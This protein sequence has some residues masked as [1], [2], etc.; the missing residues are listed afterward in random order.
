MTL[1]RPA[2]WLL[3]LATVV[4]ACDFDL[5]IDT[6]YD[7]GSDED[8]AATDEPAPA[9]SNSTSS[10]SSAST[11]PA[12]QSTS[13]ATTARPQ[14]NS[15]ASASRQAKERRHRK[16][17]KHIIARV[18][19]EKDSVS[20][21]YENVNP[22]VHRYAPSYPKTAEEISS[23]KDIVGNGRNLE[24]VDNNYED[25]DEDDDEH[26][27]RLLK[28][29]N[30]L[31]VLEMNKDDDLALTETGRSSSSSQDILLK[32]L[33]ANMEKEAKMQKNNRKH[34]LKQKQKLLEL[35]KS[36]WELLLKL[37]EKSIKHHK[38]EKNPKISQQVFILT[39]DNKNPK[40]E[41]KI[42]DKIKCQADKDN[43]VTCMKDQ[44]IYETIK[45]NPKDNSGIRKIE[46]NIRYSS[47]KDN[48]KMRESM[49]HVFNHKHGEHEGH[50]GYEPYPYH[51]SKRH[52]GHQYDDEY[53]KN[54]NHSH[55]R[56]Y[57]DTS[58]RFE[59]ENKENATNTASSMDSASPM[60]VTEKS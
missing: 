16:K 18:L 20:K 50:H 5:L 21:L 23:L 41:E 15:V 22:H 4:S 52:H 9:D 53:D 59:S 44:T 14:T 2:V 55:G 24:N 46:E 3:L 11:Q 48:S 33:I 36:A 1:R 8:D 35:K 54:D 7:D 32:L 28:F 19:G 31:G 37:I 47:V 56:P 26:T 10:S 30:I 60:P 43:Y 38:K 49:D 34:L 29:D 25:D 57:I 27:A 13:A 6:L 40:N 39:S 12:S 58:N 51:Q 42:D 45:L 17:R